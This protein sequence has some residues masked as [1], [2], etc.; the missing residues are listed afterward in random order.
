MSN[1]V[2]NPR[3]TLDIIRSDAKVGL[4]D[5]RGLIVGQISA[6]AAADITDGMYISDVPRSPEEINELFGP[7]SH[8]ALLARS[9]RE[10][11]EYTNLSAI[12][13][14]D[15]GASITFDN[16]GELFNAADPTA[17]TLTI[18]AHD[19]TGNYERTVRVGVSGIVKV[20][21]DKTC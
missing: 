9:Y 18:R 19:C 14:E 3:V 6:N 5:Q 17:I 7:D 12:V 20:L 4:E 21:S 16:S 8:L 15:D 1:A 11:N 2:S 13:L 10:V